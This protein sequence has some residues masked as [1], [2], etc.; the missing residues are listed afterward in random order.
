MINYLSSTTQLAPL[1]LASLATALPDVPDTTLILTL[2][3]IWLW[4]WSTICEQDSEIWQIRSGDFCSWLLLQSPVN[5][6]NFHN[7]LPVFSAG[8]T[9]SNVIPSPGWTTWVRAQANAFLEITFSALTATITL[10][11]AVLVARWLELESV[12]SGNIRLWFVKLKYLLF[13]EIE[14]Y[15]RWWEMFRLFSLCVMIV[16]C[17]WSCLLKRDKVKAKLEFGTMVSWL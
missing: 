14:N 13:D 1:L 10:S 16:L 6:G 2:T 9:A 15:K 4:N 7:L 8:K 11:A 17:A 12:L 3:S 5:L